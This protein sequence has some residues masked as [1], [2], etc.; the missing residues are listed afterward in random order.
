MTA[1]SVSSSSA[2]CTVLLVGESGKKAF[3]QD[4]ILQ[5]VVQLANPFQ[6]RQVSDPDD[7]RIKNVLNGHGCSSD[8]KGIV[9][10]QVGP[11]EHGNVLKERNSIV[12][13]LCGMALHGALDLRHQLLGGHSGGS[14]RGTSVAPIAALAWGCLTEWMGIAQALRNLPIQSNT[15]STESFGKIVDRM[16]YHLSSHAFLVP[17]P[18]ATI[19]DLDVA[20]VILTRSDL[21]EM[22]NK[23]SSFEK[24]RNVGRWLR[25]C[26]SDLDL[27]GILEICQTAGISFL[28][29]PP[30]SSNARGAPVFF[31]GTESFFSQTHATTVAPGTSSPQGKPSQQ[32]QAAVEGK[33]KNEARD[34]KKDPTD[35][36]ASKK[37]NK[38]DMK[39][40]PDG[41]K[42]PSAP[43]ASSGDTAAA[44]AAAGGVAPSE[45]NIGMLDIRVG[46]IVNVWE[47]ESAEKLF[48]EEIDLGP[49]LGSRKI[50]S[51]LR[52][53]YKLEEMQGRTVLVL[54]N[55]K[56]RNLVGFPSHGMVLCAS[57][58]DH[59]S[60]EFV[61]P[62]DGARLGSR[63][64]FDGYE[65]VTP[66]PENK[67]AKKKIFE[68][69]APHLK[70]DSDG[71]VIWK[72]NAAARVQG[73]EE[74]SKDSSRVRAL[75][76]MPN[77]K[78][79]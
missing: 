75:N 3:Q 46:K 72:K 78:V 28:E 23:S 38:K 35:S 57:N 37:K 65:S 31:S 26:K 49:E 14:V 56:S 47:H 68:T 41:A 7:V 2:L 42:K 77:A 34:N 52:P 53:F 9:A 67:V 79:S 10:L 12:R 73:M 59:T 19:A 33:K 50:A 44:A 48:C 16:E 18:S 13:A 74:L 40:T 45:P 36:S 39:N 63:V 1:G 51:G 6:I 21:L 30:P 5:W 62:P 70:T 71:Y 61:I 54:C 58:A 20:S 69:V 4:I 76:G 8:Q 11:H 24:Y 29:P 64:V 22:I 66:E 15:N 27:Y 43:A 60:V 25:Q 55:L 17:S 32:K